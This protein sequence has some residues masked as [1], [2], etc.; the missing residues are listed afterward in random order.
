MKPLSFLILGA[1]SPMRRLH[2]AN[3]VG[4]PPRDRVNQ[5]QQQRAI[6]VRKAEAPVHS[7]VQEVRRQGT[8]AVQE[9][10]LGANNVGLV[11]LQLHS[12]KLGLQ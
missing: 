12:V 8:N 10:R 5:G 9:V 11:K 7:A 4:V 6:I 2:N 1:A 3:Q